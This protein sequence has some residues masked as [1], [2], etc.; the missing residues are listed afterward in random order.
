MSKNG[1]HPGEDSEPVQKTN[2]KEP[3]NLLG[4]RNIY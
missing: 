2:V 3:T 4:R 1:L